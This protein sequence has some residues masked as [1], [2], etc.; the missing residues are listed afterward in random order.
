[1]AKEAITIMKIVINAW[2]A[3]LGGGQTYIKNLLSHLPENADLSVLL[4]APA[5]LLIPNDNRIH[6]GSTRW[7]VRN[8]LLRAVWDKLILPSILSREKADI[9]FCPGGVV[10]TRT[11]VNCRVVTMFRNMTPFDPISLKEIPFGIFLIRNWILK[12][13][14]LRSMRSADL[15]IFVSDYARSVIERLVRVKR[16]VVIPH[17][18]NDIFRVNNSQLPYPPEAPKLPYILYVS[19][20]DSYKHHLEVLTGYA[21][22]PLDLQIKYPLVFV[23]GTSHSTYAPVRALIDAKN[24]QERVHIVGDIKYEKLPAFYANSK[25]IIFASSCEN[26]P[27][28]LLEGLASGRPTLSSNVMPMPDFG[29]PGIEY[30]S[31]FDPQQICE[32]LHRVITNT[33]RC[34]E[35][36]N[37]ALSASEKFN[38]SETARATWFSLRGILS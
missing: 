9:L 37:A 7:P 33:D 12:R 26:C 19:R 10:S 23:G 13:V 2:S 28:I 14:M 38:W 35:V 8:P 32:S 29:G 1:M 17:G 4:F 30:F 24:M 20:F 11:P 15:T 3:R 6:R 5:D 21:G 25:L 18:I 31:P 16:S 36:A 34:D 27:N 22:L